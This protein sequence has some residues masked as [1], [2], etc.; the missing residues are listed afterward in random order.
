MG[1]L[2]DR[3]AEQGPVGQA[4][5]SGPAH[6]VPRRQERQLRQRAATPQET[7]D[8]PAGAVPTDG[9]PAGP[10]SADR[11]RNRRAGRGP[12]RTPPQDARPAGRAIPFAEGLQRS[13][14]YTVDR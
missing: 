12:E 6:R 1:R 2:V 13:G 7:G 9:E 4:D 14:L 10:R 5:P 11:L 8:E 3:A